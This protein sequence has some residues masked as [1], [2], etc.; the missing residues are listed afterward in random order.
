[1][2]TLQLGSDTLAVTPS[3]GQVEFNGQMYYTDSNS[4]RGQIER[5]VQGTSVASTSGTSITFTGI[6]AWA[7]RI[8]VMFNG[9]S[10]SGTSRMQ[11]QLGSGSVTTTGYLSQASGIGSTGNNTV[12]SGVI[13]TGFVLN[14]Y[15][16]I[17]SQAYSGNMVFTNIS[18]NIW[19]G[20]GV[21]SE[22]TGNVG[23]TM[24]GGTISL[25]NIL[26]RVV[27]TTVN[28]TDTFDAGSINI[29]YEG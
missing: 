26:D 8:T 23:V 27:V 21:L 10:T 3:A 1:M 29:M 17:A 6:P 2:S 24:M 13:T 25:S 20:S 28:G 5:L 22:N 15:A 11:L 16:P 19:I 18:G 14:G 9:V 12:T 7:K 4:S